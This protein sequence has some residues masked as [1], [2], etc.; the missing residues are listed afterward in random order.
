M[1]DDDND[2]TTAATIIDFKKLNL[3]DDFLHLRTKHL[4]NAEKTMTL[5]QDW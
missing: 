2:I 1:K 5:T 3:I 4:R